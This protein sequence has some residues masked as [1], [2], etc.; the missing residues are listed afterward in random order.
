[1]N[2]EE[3][4]TKAKKIGKKALWIGLI[5]IILFSAGYYTYRTYTKSEGTRSGILFKIS[6][7]GIVFKTYEGQLQLAGATIMNKESVWEFSATNAE[8]YQT[9]QNLEGKHVRL[10]YHE[11]TDSFP[12]QGDTN[13]L[14]YKAEEVKE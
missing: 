14:V 4:K 9:L 7:K 13:Y 8:V 5:S 6:K 10:Y 3:T 12:W 2:L 1:M 11:I